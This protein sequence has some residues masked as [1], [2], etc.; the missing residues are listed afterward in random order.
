MD[1]HSGIGGAAALVE[2][3]MLL[4]GIGALVTRRAG[5]RPW[6]TVLFGINAGFGDVSKDTL[7]GRPVVDVVLLLLA[8]AAYAG[9]WPGP[10]AHETGWMILA[11]A[12]PLAGVP[13]LAATRQVGR[14]G[15]MGGALV[16]SL[17]M[18][19]DGTRTGAGWLGVTASLL[20]LVGDFGT[21]GR[22]SRPLA[23]LV[24]VGYI[25]LVAWFVWVAVLLL[26]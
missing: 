8:G 20:L 13:L 1:V 15:L 12:Q 9:F 23:T 26:R 11:V 3:A 18:L 7:R 14:S 2:A 22:R 5:A 16:L 25:A 24:A 17:V 4:V 6:L 19:V 10:G 21:T